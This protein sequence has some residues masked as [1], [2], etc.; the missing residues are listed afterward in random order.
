MR[1][2]TITTGLLIFGIALLCGLP[3][4][5][6]RQPGADAPRTE[7]AQYAVLFG[8]YTMVIFAVAIA[9]IVCAMIV[10]RRTATDLKA[11]SKLNMEM[12]VEGSLRDHAAKKANAAS[13]NGQPAFPDEDSGLAD[14]DFDE[15]PADPES[16]SS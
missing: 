15:A 2:K 1:L 10:L 13:L 6:G 5:M 14:E 3:I 9:V 8:S 12:F 16:K 7:K 4:L 11:Q